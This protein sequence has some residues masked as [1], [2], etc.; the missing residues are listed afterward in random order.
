MNEKLDILQMLHD[1]TISVDEASKLLEAVSGAGLAEVDTDKGRAF[2]KESAEPPAVPP[3]MGRFRRL[4][5]IPFAL[6]LAILALTGGGAYA[7]YLRTE[8][9]IT[10]G[11]VVL[12]ALC[13]LALLITAL[14]LWATTVPWLH[15]RI[16]SAPDKGSFGTRIA[17]SL[18][19]PLTLAG[20]GLRLA[21]RFVDRE[22]A[23]HL[24]AAT[25]LVQAMR[26][27]LGKPGA[28]PIV[29]DV[30]D[31]DERVQVYIG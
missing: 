17:I 7:L 21:H 23:G 4:S 18:P 27:D 29:V 13:V 22:T 10:F 12:L 11:F 26:Q 31:E 28:E 3:D 6:S 30:H 25:A 14:A 24:N 5:Y 9:R 8:G 20:W 1:G 19:V 15:V 2:S 16:R